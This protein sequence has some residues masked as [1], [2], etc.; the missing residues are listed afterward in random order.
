MSNPTFKVKVSGSLVEGK[1][2]KDVTGLAA[3]VR[4]VMNEQNELTLGRI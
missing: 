2:W 4:A 3:A 1:Q